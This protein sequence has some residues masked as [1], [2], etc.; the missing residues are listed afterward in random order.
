MPSCNVI[1]TTH[2]YEI[3]ITGFGLVIRFIEHLKIITTSNYRANAN[4]HVLQFITARTKS[5]QSAASSPVVVW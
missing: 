3:I 2:I 1:E 5:A 4:S